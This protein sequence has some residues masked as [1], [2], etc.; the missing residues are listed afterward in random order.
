[1]TRLTSP[2]YLLELAATYARSA[3][4]E[5]LAAAERLREIA[6]ELDHLIAGGTVVAQPRTPARG[7]TT[8]GTNRKLA[9]IRAAQQA[10]PT[11][12][13]MQAI[14]DLVTASRN[15]TP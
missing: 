12:D 14:H 13:E 5:H 6:A 8:A 4:P 2:A 11:P 7:P 9:D 1:M 10:A 3:K 15:K